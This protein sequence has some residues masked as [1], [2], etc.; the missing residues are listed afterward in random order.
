LTHDVEQMVSP[1][2]DFPQYA[3]RVLYPGLTTHAILEP[4]VS[5]LPHYLLDSTANCRGVL[6]AISGLVH[7]PT[8][9]EFF[10]MIL[11]SK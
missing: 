1:Y 7:I 10:V 4:N 9:T 3:M 2:L 11:F 6:S 8:L 5:S